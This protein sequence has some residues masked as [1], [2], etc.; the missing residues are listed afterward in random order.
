M[1]AKGGFSGFIL[2]GG[3]KGL[4]IASLM[5]VISYTGLAPF[6]KNQNYPWN[7]MKKI[8]GSPKRQ[9]MMI[10][11]GMLGYIFGVQGDYFEGVQDTD[12][13]NRLYS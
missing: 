7:A 2:G 6:C 11:K 5:Y 4:N 3:V 12:A 1:T 13:I 10:T 8:K 9:L